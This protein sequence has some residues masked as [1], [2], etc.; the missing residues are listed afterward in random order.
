M[1]IGICIVLQY[2]SKERHTVHTHRRPQ[3]ITDEVISDI[4]LIDSPEPSE[5]EVSINAV[6]VRPS[7]DISGALSRL[8]VLPLTCTVS[9]VRRV[10]IV[11]FLHI[12]G[13]LY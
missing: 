9:L 10:A 2:S 8:S 4:G 7:N 13:V 11:F 1:N 6:Y 3:S 12:N 5:S